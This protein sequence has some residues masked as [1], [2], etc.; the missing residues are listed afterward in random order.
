MPPRQPAAPILERGIE[1]LK[2]GLSALAIVALAS[3]ALIVA[4]C[5]SNDEKNAYVD[6]VNAIQQDA[7]DAV[8][9]ATTANPQN[10]QDFITQLAAAEKAIDV[11]IAQLNAVDV[12]SD[13]EEGHADFVA[14]LQA[15][16]DLFAEVVECANRHGLAMVMTGR[17]QFRH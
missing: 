8:T 6:E 12:P 15:M 4:G 11:A 16:S 13:A 1:V 14:D 2:K 10:K 17:R 7:L 5:G 9:T 3:L